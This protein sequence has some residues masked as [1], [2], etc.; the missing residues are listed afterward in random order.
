VTESSSPSNTSAQKPLWGIFVI[1]VAVSA[2]V[3]I[4]KLFRAKEIVPWRTDFI[5][6]REESRTSHK[7]IL[8][9]FTA[10][11]CG[12]CDEMKHTTWADKHVEETLRDYVPVKIDIDHNL[13]L[14]MK[15]NADPIPLL[16]ILNDEGHIVRQ[17]TGLI[18]PADFVLWLK[19]PGSAPL[20]PT[21]EINH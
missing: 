4:S 12:P 13:D 1:L 16:A 17:Y 10:D 9:Y 15:Y 18:E 14:A 6:A 7:P 11:W 5:A 8:A 20:K 3:T 19:G 21:L 2:L